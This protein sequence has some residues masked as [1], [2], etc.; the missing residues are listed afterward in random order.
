M[1]SLAE[2][3]GIGGRE[4]EPM[5]PAPASTSTPP[6][7]SVNEDAVLLPQTSYGIIPDCPVTTVA[8]TPATSWLQ[9]DRPRVMQII[10]GAPSSVVY[11]ISAAISEAKTNHTIHMQ[12]T[13]TATVSAGAVY[14]VFALP[15]AIYSTYDIAKNWNRDSGLDRTLKIAGNIA[16]YTYSAKGL[17][18]LVN[19][20]APLSSLIHANAALAGTVGAAL[21][22]IG[23]G[24][25]AIVYTVKGFQAAIQAYKLS[26]Q[27]D[28]AR[29]DRDKIE[30]KESVASKIMNGVCKSLSNQKK[31]SLL[32]CL[33]SFV[34]AIGLGLATA[35]AIGVIIGVSMTP[36]G[37][38]A[39]GIVFVGLLINAGV[40]AY[41]NRQ[42]AALQQTV[43][44][45]L[46]KT[47]TPEIQQKLLAVTGTDV[48]KLSA[49]VEILQNAAHKELAK[50][51]VENQDAHIEQ[52]T[53]LFAEPTAMESFLKLLPGEQ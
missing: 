21:G 39:A 27:L 1:A 12:S 4:L 6:P 11:C 51:G 7:L 10:N 23:P 49:R 36:V 22:P 19:T 50:A 47:I 29:A 46:A 25:G 52:I 13:D 2:A 32:D 28:Q 33:R 37:W 41:K 53:K 8:A 43:Q 31:T 42:T 35:V 38:A 44:K 26:G 34:L 17:A 20:V 3:G 5:Q 15:L 48:K 40:I 9:A 18:V 30:N 16:L 14:A 24:L 45:D